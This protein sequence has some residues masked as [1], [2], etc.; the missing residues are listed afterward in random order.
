[1]SAIREG[2]ENRFYPTGQRS[3]PNRNAVLSDQCKDWLTHEI[4]ANRRRQTVEDRLRAIE[5]DP[6]FTWEALQLR[7]RNTQRKIRK[8]RAVKIR[9][10]V[11]VKAQSQSK[12]KSRPGSPARASRRRRSSQASQT[13]KL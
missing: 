11:K 1:M 13:S 9:V 2:R 3:I 4:M 7:H 8:L 6:D 5:L 12:R 10:R